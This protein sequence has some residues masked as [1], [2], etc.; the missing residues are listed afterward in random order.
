MKDPKK[1]Q[2]QAAS[3]LK[4]IEALIEQADAQARDLEKQLR[5]RAP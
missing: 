1:L 4:E 5:R 3:L 2:D